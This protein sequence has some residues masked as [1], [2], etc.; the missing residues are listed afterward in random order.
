[1]KINR[2]SGKFVIMKFAQSLSQQK[3]FGLPYLRSSAKFEA[4]FEGKVFTENAVSKTTQ[5]RLLT[6]ILITVN[7]AVF[8]KKPAVAGR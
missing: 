1:M 5:R 4:I 8:V 7:M 3:T 2:I 6:T